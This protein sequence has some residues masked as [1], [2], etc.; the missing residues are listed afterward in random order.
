LSARALYCNPAKP[1]AFSTLDNLTNALPM[2][3]KSDVRAWLEQREAYSKHIPV[4]KRF[5]RNP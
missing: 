3:K 2:E 1:S 5:L 4:R